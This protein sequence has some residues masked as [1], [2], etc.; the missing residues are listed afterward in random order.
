M[1]LKEVLRRAIRRLAKVIAI[2]TAV[3]FLMLTLVL[4]AMKPVWFCATACDFETQ[5]RLRA[6]WHEIWT[7]LRSRAKYGHIMF[8][9]ALV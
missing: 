6:R 9:E 5:S 2:G 7:Y 3:V 1:S 4:P 8:E